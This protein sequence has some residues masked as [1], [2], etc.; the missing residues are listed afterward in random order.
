MTT[1]LLPASEWAEKLAGTL[2]ESAVPSLPP[3]SAVLAVEDDGRVVACV[4]L[5]PVWHLEGVWIAPEQRGTVGVARRLVRAIRGVA[6]TLGLD[7]AWMMARSPEA[8]RMCRRFGG[9]LHLDCDHF[10]VR[11]K[12]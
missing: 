1:R 9:A 12:E 5:F 3:E 2:L 4:A 6:A 11:F 7:G 8:A 10:A